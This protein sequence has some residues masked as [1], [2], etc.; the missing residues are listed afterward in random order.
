MPKDAAYTPLFVAVKLLDIGLVTIYFFVLGLA[1]AKI[2][3]NMLGVFEEDNYDNIPTWQI[4]LEII[5]QLFFIGVIAYVL[6]NLV[7]LIPFP[8]DG[9]AGFEHIRLKEL[10]GGE[11]MA[12]VLILFQRSLIDKVLYFV[13][14]VLGIKTSKNVE[15]L[16]GSRGK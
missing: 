1:A 2:F 16:K 7:K 4:F 5:L 3:D 14:R 15:V 6:R 11:V 13:N 12:L 10:D 8:L 9:V